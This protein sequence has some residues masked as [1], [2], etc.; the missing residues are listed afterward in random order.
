MDRGLADAEPLRGHP[1]GRFV[2]DD[3]KGQVTGP[4]FDV[5]AQVLPLPTL[6]VSHIYVGG[7]GIIRPF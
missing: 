1:D 4:F 7:G 2:L 3:V 5:R 6:T